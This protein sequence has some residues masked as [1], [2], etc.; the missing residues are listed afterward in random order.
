MWGLGARFGR[1]RGACGDGEHGAAGVKSSHHDNEKT[2][3]RQRVRE[4]LIK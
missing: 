2:T 1:L 4:S 3:R